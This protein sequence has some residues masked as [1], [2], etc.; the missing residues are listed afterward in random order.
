VVSEEISD[1]IQRSLEF[2]HSTTTEE[3]VDGIMLSGGCAKIKGLDRFLANRLGVSV[4]IANPFRRLRCSERMFDPEYLRD[5]APLAAVSVG[6]AL[7]RV[8]D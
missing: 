8:H 2:F 4:D 1:E 7:R 6:L 3:T 5:I